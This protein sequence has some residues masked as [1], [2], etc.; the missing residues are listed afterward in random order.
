MRAF[1]KSTSSNVMNVT[2]LNETLSDAVAVQS[3]KSATSA[4]ACC[5][6]DGDVGAVLSARRRAIPPN[7]D[8]HHLQYVSLARVSAA[9]PSVCTSAV[10]SAGTLVQSNGTPVPSRDQTSAIYQCGTNCAC[11]GRRRTGN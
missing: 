4:A 2:R 9:R 3:L 1:V 8:Q 11:D 7:C 10:S 5:R 6:D